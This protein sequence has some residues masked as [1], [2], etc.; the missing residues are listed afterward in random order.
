M[1]FSSIV[2][3]CPNQAGDAAKVVFDFGYSCCLNEYRQVKAIADK[4]GWLPDMN[5]SYFINTTTTT[6]YNAA[7]RKKMNLA[8]VVGQI[9]TN[10]GPVVIFNLS[11]GD[12]MLDISRVDTIAKRNNF[13]T[14]H[15]RCYSERDSYGNLIYYNYW[16]KRQP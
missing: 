3:F 10:T 14:D 1:K 2:E 11:R 7:W 12:W 16:I 5:H 4:Y 9:N 8:S 13:T 15:D 6:L